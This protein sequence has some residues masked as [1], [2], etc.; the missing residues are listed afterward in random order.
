MI[1]YRFQ[2]DFTYNVCQAYIFS[3]SSFCQFLPF[4]PQ[5]FCRAGYYRFLPLVFSA[6]AKTCQPCVKVVMVSYKPGMLG[7]WVLLVWEHTIWCDFEYMS[8]VRFWQHIRTTLNSAVVVLGMKVILQPFLRFWA[9]GWGC[10]MESLLQG[11][12]WIVHMACTI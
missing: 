10:Q 11:R 1:I 4:L 8:W 9:C 12:V 2:V 3:P 7:S 6:L 5:G